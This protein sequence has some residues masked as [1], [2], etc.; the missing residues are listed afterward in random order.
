MLRDFTVSEKCSIAGTSQPFQYQIPATHP[1]DERRRSM[2]HTAST[3]RPQNFRSL[4]GC[5]CNPRVYSR[6]PLLA[7][8]SAN[9]QADNLLM[10]CLPSSSSAYLEA[11]VNLMNDAEYRLALMRDFLCL[12]LKIHMQALSSCQAR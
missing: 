12:I 1:Q 7:R 11:C 8:Q 5:T 2:S 4:H 10:I 6:R 3:Q 9:G